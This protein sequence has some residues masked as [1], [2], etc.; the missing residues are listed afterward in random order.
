MVLGQ[1]PVIIPYPCNIWKLQTF[2]NQTEVHNARRNDEK[3]P[4]A[5]S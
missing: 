4:L 2:V 1:V 5:K 3:P